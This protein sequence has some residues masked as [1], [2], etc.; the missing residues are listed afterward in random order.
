MIQFYNPLSIS[1]KG[2]I[3]RV[4]Y[5]QSIKNRSKHE[6]DFINH[7]NMLISH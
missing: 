1:R 5:Y 2:I 4:V 7:S 3:N 6:K